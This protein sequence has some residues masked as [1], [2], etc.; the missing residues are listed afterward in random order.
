MSAAPTGYRDFC[1]ITRQWIGLEARTHWC[2]GSHCLPDSAGH[3][4]YT[5][6]GHRRRNQ[7]TKNYKVQTCPNRTNYTIDGLQLKAKQVWTCLA[8]ID[9]VT[10]Q[11][12]P[13]DQS[14]CKYSSKHRFIH[15]YLLIPGC[16]YPGVYKSRLHNRVD[17]LLL[18]WKPKGWK[19]PDSNLPH[20]AHPCWAEAC[21]HTQASSM[22]LRISTGEPLIRR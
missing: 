6:E 16:T 14:L 1:E 9:H 4:N 21:S 12:S 2:I 13:S 5:P 3:V 11:S 10:S 19:F 20:A 22:S 15:V 8:D 17:A 18:L 7:C